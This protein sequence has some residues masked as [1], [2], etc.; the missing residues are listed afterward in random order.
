MA[1]FVAWT[2][3]VCFGRASN[4]DAR[5][6]QEQNKLHAVRPAIG[7]RTA[8]DATPVARE[9]AQQKPLTC[10][11][12]MQR[13]RSAT[14]WRMR[15][16]FAWMHAATLGSKFRQSPSTLKS[17]LVSSQQPFQP[18]SA[19]VARLL[20]CLRRNRPG[21]TQAHPSNARLV[22]HQFLQLSRLHAR[23]G[24]EHGVEAVLGQDLASAQDTL[25]RMSCAPSAQGPNLTQCRTKQSPSCGAPPS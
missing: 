17:W 19:G 9:A 24:T 2:R 14:H 21:Q 15:P 22:E 13:Q 11:K 7:A 6:T 8:G 23:V 20:P 25:G 1:T 10:G 18:G 5:Y 3:R 16:P 4:N 12:A